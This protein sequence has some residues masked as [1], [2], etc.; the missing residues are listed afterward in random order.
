M[1]LSQ[2]GTTSKFP[3][4]FLFFHFTLTLNTQQLVKNQ[5]EC[6]YHSIV[7]SHTTVSLLTVEYVWLIRSGVEV[8]D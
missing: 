5:C 3:P 7:V 1:Q 2:I 4:S 6:T 8:L